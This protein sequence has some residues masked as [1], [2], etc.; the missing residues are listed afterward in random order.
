M[1][2]G[3]IYRFIYKNESGEYGNVKINSPIKCR[4]HADLIFQR[5]DLKQVWYKIEF[6]GYG[7]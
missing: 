6:E 3:Y 1:T 4:E 7:I 5:M 2:K